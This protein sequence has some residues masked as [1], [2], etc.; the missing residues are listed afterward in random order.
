M[1]LL[2]LQELAHYQAN[3]PAA[4]ALACS[5]VKAMLLLLLR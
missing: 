5:H 1:L 4:A 3:T 2:L